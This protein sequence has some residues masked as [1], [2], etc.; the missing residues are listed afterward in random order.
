MS[1]ISLLSSAL[2]KG[3]DI[4]NAKIGFLSYGSGSKA[5]IF[6][7]TL[8]NQWEEIIKGLDLFKKLEDRIQIDIASYEKLH[9]NEMILPLDASSKSIKLDKIESEDL[10]VGLRKFKKYISFNIIFLTLPS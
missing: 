2:E 4:N 1:L 9:N 3:Q 8:E 6:E 10:T 7:G 5:K